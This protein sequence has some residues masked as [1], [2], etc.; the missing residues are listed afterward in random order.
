MAL[1]ESGAP[2]GTLPG[3]QREAESN[4]ATPAEFKADPLAQREG[5]SRAA[6][7]TDTEQTSP[8]QE[9][10][11][12]AGTFAYL[13]SALKG[14]LSVPDLSGISDASGVTTLINDE[15]FIKDLNKLRDLR[16]FL[17]QEA[18]PIGSD[19]IEFG[20]LNLLRHNI[21]PDRFGRSPTEEEWSQVESYTRILFGLLTPSLRRRFLLGG[22]PSLLAWLPI[23]LA[24]IALVSLILAI[25]TFD[26]PIFTEIGGGSLGANV[27]PFYLVWL[28]SLGAIGSVSF[29]GMNALSVQEDITFDLTNVRLMFLRITLGALF[30][31]VLTLPFGFG[32]FLQFCQTIVRGTPLQETGDAT[33]NT[34]S[35][36]ALTFQ[37]IML[38]LPFILG[39]ST[40]LVILILNRFVDAVQA[41]FGR[42]EQPVL[43]APSGVPTSTAILTG[44]AAA[45]AAEAAGPH[46]ET[47]VQRRQPPPRRKA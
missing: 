10:E 17:I 40:S 37:A 36:P 16:S 29:I 6:Y 11:G 31:L 46:R 23:V 14:A 28:M 32:G 18:I 34:G 8:G 2:K 45:R 35:V 5:K 33:A 39:F 41:F 13:K 1:D 19:S 12:D 21:F 4:T 26:R 43:T 15:R 25:I 24:L 42:R 30:G 7:A 27:L 3:L 22:V 44:N 20:R 47:R 9:S 38:V